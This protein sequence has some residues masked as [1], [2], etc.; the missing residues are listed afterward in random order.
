MTRFIFYLS[1]IIA[2]VV[3]EV[4]DNKQCSKDDISCNSASSSIV[5]DEAKYAAYPKKDIT[6]RKD[7]QIH[8][9]LDEIESVRSKDPEVAL[10][11]N[12]KLLSE[13]PESPRAIQSI[14]LTYRRL[15]SILS[16]ENKK[17]GRLEYLDPMLQNLLRF[18][19][20]D[21]ETVPVD[22][23]TSVIDYGLTNSVAMGQRDITVKILEQMI[24]KL[25]ELDQEDVNYYIQSYIDELF[26]AENYDKV[27]EVIIKHS[28]PA[29][30]PPI[31]FRFLMA[32]LSRIEDMNSGKPFPTHNDAMLEQTLP[33]N[34]VE[35]ND[36][37]IY[38][39]DIVKELR[40]KDRI[41]IVNIVYD[42]MVDLKIYPSRYQRILHKVD[43]L[44]AKPVWG[45]G[46]LEHYSEKLIELEQNWETLRD[47]AVELVRLTPDHNIT[48]SNKA[49]V[50]NP[51]SWK[52]YFYHGLSGSGL[53][54][55][56]NMCSITPTICNLLKDYP[57]TKLCPLGQV[58]L[59][60][61]EPNTKLKPFN[62]QS[63]FRLRAQLP[64][65]VGGK[66]ES[67]EASELVALKINGKTTLNYE[68]G[69]VLLFD[70]SFEQ[71]MINES[72]KPLL[73]LTVDL[74]H[75]DMTEKMFLEVKEFAENLERD[76]AM[77][78]EMAGKA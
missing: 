23:W 70:D 55:P 60:Y 74:I 38:V 56:D 67:T 78:M 54:F 11:M 64:L 8:E 77:Q 76:L 24:T 73:I 40:K 51:H 65:I 53:S 66:N 12:K 27:R 6:S 32:V 45:F 59:D 62:S 41:Q 20:L 52:Q 44:T 58:K 35:K 17:I 48:L 37:I 15:F 36:M 49:F 4:A 39:E 7:F 3:C 68:A 1:V 57:V 69:K 72:G 50:D 28:N 31:E 26:Y 71:Q 9:I 5:F 42:L 61:L 10:V 16:D 34:E 29:Q 22:L 19:E 46:E 13:H 63:N 21:R 43:A 30:L 75:P 18:S 47:E 14:C 33:N 2:T 25:D